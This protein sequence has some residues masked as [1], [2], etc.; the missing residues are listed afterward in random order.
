MKEIIVFIMKLQM[1]FGPNV[2]MMKEIIV[3]IMK[4]Q[5]AFGKNTHMM[6]TTMF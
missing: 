6:K 5:M 4:T 3:F 1:A 2:N